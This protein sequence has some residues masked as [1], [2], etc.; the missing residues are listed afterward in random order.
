MRASFYSSIEDGMFQKSLR[1]EL[2]NLGVQSDSVHAVGLDDYRSATGIIKRT[3]LRAKMYPWYIAK[4]AYTWTMKPVD[5]ILVTTTNPFFLS[6]VATK[7]IRERRSKTVQLLWDLFPDALIQ[8][9][10]LNRNSLSGR[11]LSGMTKQS[12]ERCDA[13]V[14]LGD[15]LKSYAESMYGIA[16]KGVVIPVGADGEP[17][18]ESKPRL[19]ESCSE[20]RLLY[21]GNM[22]Q[23]HD[24]VTISKALSKLALSRLRLSA[25]FFGN[26]QGLSQIRDALAVRRGNLT[27]EV[28]SG[29]DDKQW[30]ST[31]KKASIALVTMRPGAEQVVMPSKTYSA[32]MAGQA[33]IAVCSRKSDLADLVCKYDCGWIIE[34]GEFEE[35]AELLEHIAANP[36][37]VYIKRMN[38]YSV[39][40]RLFSTKVLA[41]QWFD[42]FK[43]IKGT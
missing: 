33:I 38:A 21:C 35:M 6:Y 17:F 16:N 40:H 8:A 29:L 42:L 26:G 7:V 10:T 3:L 34:P 41:K 31:M 27:V 2:G 1:R 32:L 13:T 30:V 11:W 5:H 12:L 19:D 4:C 22:G 20:L 9:G 15:H 24:S 28:G 23:M 36:Q 18:A 43:S 25:K 39:G 37:T 14:F